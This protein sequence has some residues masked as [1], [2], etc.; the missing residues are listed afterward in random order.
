MHSEPDLND[1]DIELIVIRYPW[2]VQTVIGSLL[3]IPVA[4]LMVR[5]VVGRDVKSHIESIVVV[6]CLWSLSSFW[7]ARRRM[8]EISQY[9]IAY[10]PPIGVTKKT[11]FADVT[12]IKKVFMREFGSS[13]VRGMELQLSN[14]MALGISLDL[15]N[16]DEVFDK[17]TKAWESQ[18]AGG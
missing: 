1:K 6:A 3:S 14:Y 11:K 13:S 18:R 9:G 10:R 16:G 12:S 7:M 5:D 8:L 2:V 15:P 4:I 17:I